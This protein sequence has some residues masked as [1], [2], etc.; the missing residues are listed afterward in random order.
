M[1]ATRHDP[2]DRRRSLPPQGRIGL[3]RMADG[4]RVRVGVWP[5]ADPAKGSV[6]LLNGR[7]DFIEKYAETI[8]DWTGR[9]VGV[10]SLDWRGQGGSDRPLSDPQKGHAADFGPWIDDLDALAAAYRAELPAPHRIVA[11]SMGGHLTVRHLLRGGSA[12]VPVALLAPM[13]GL[14]PPPGSAALAR[15]AVAAGLG[16]RF[17]LLQ[18]SYGAWQQRP[19]RAALLTGDLGRFADE[20]WWLAQHPEWQ[21]GGVTWGW[22]AA[23]LR[24]IAI[25][26]APGVLEGVANPVLVLVGARERLVSAGAAE[27][28][29]ARMPHARFERIA[30]ARHELL[31][32]SDDLRA[33]VLAKLDAFLNIGA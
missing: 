3:R 12:G 19:E 15:W 23:A 14:T 24:S 9:G 17:A 25:L 18:R 21:L 32:E 26:D 7:A 2:A 1:F 27:T 16:D 4:V 28:A 11:H 31:R 8:W 30:G 29:A 22:L 5:A 6:L 10:M 13:F 33:E 20:H